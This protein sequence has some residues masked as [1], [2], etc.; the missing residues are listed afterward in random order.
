M[1]VQNH[2][3]CQLMESTSQDELRRLDWKEK[4]GSERDE[5]GRVGSEGDDGEG[6]I[7]KRR[8]GKDWAGEG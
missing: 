7:G 5:L 4:V 2:F 3:E 1:Q 6:L 8:V